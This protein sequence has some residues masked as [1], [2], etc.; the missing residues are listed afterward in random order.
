MTQRGKNCTVNI[1]IMTSLE[2]SRMGMILKKFL[3]NER[4]QFKIIEE[5]VNTIIMDKL[6]P[7]G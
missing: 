5:Q 3:I 1:R 6:I 4:S 7:K 2:I